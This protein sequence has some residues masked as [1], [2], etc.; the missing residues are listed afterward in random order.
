MAVYCHSH[1][2][3][4]TDENRDDGAKIMNELA[5]VFLM[6]LKEQNRILER[7][8]LH[9]EWVAEEDEIEWVEPFDWPWTEWNR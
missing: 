9:E 5:R 8:R 2:F 3:V 1:R 4:S 6:W 7:R